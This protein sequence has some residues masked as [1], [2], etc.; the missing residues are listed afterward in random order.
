MLHK[1]LVSPAEVFL[2][3]ENFSKNSKI[4][5]IFLATT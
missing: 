1:D 4:Q 5:N 2:F 3:L